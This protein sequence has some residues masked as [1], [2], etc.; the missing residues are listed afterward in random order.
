LIKSSLIFLLLL[1]GPYALLLAFT[2]VA[3]FFL[4]KQK[5]DAGAFW[6]WA[7]IV[8][9]GVVWLG[10]SASPELLGRRF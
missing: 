5:A 2:F 4:P 1:G 10:G 9:T 7:A 3:R 6:T 8:A